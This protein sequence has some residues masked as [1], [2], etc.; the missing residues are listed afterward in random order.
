MLARLIRNL[1]PL[2]LIIL[3][4]LVFHCRICGCSLL[5]F[6]LGH[7]LFACEETLRRRFLLFGFRV[8]PN[9]ILVQWLPL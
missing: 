3:F 5:R 8:L 4:L 9:N 2:S 6:D 1:A 7:N